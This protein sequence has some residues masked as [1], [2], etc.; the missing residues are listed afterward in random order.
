MSSRLSFPHRLI[1]ERIGEKSQTV[2]PPSELLCKVQLQTVS[3]YQFQ[4]SFHHGIAFSRKEKDEIS[5]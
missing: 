2:K 3:E 4:M 5:C 1:A